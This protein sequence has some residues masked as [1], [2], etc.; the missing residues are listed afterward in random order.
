ME[1][2]RWSRRNRHF[3]NASSSPLE[4][5]LHRSEYIRLLLACEPHD[6]DR[7]LA[8][9][10]LHLRAFYAEHTA[11]FR[12]LMTCVAYLPRT[13]LE[14]SPYADLASLNVH[15]DLESLFA[16][17]YCASMDMSRQIPLR[18]IGDIGA[19]G[20][21]ARIEKARTVMKEKKSEW[22]QS[23]ELPV[24]DWPRRRRRPT[25]VPRSRLSCP[26][27][28]ATTPSLHVQCRRNS[29]QSRTHQ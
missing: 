4:F 28:I 12:R 14:S 21:L 7:A 27:R 3:L 10:N 1:R 5:Y 19:G 25:D 13:R 24:S 2:S 15:T 18:V 16:R 29:L 6:C 22:T 17:E 26:P 9:A 20:A 8:Y 11:E 23:D